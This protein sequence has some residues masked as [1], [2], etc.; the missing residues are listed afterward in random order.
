MIQKMNKQMWPAK[1]ARSMTPGRLWRLEG[2]GAEDGGVALGAGFREEVVV[3]AEGAG[4]AFS[5]DG[6]DVS[7]TSL[8][9][10]SGS[11]SLL[12]H[13]N[14]YLAL[15]FIYRSG[16]NVKELRYSFHLALLSKSNFLKRSTAAE[17]IIE[18]LHNSRIIKI[19]LNTTMQQ[20]LISYYTPRRSG[21]LSRAANP[22]KCLNSHS[23]HRQ[24]R[25][26]S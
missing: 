8:M 3:G 9:S 26:A 12:Y 20:L 22:P 7:I 2:E 14:W 18:V 11:I 4:I 10:K 25:P 15:Y 23:L 13:F 19:L 16:G 24:S 5:P 17:G 1:R 21:L 6:D